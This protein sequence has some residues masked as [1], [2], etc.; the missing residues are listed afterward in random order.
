MCV[1]SELWVQTIRVTI[2]VHR[3]LT[4]LYF[5]IEISHSISL[6][7]HR[8]TFSSLHFQTFTNRGASGA[9]KRQKKN[10]NKT[11]DPHSNGNVFGACEYADRN[12]N[13]IKNLKRQNSILGAHS[14]GFIVQ[15]FRFLQ[16]PKTNYKRINHCEITVCGHRCRR[17]HWTKTMRTTL[18]YKWF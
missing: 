11:Y 12:I 2:I 18:K 3:T 9:Q 5:D 15:T 17:H 13:G 14:F 8:N 7:G 4:S 10:N 6:S 1:C 16:L